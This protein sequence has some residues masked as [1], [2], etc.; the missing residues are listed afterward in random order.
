MPITGP[1]THQ[2][3]CSK[4]HIFGWFS[5]HHKTVLPLVSIS[6]SVIMS[7]GVARGWQLWGPLPKPPW[8]RRRVLHAISYHTRSPHGGKELRR[9]VEGGQGGRVVG[10]GGGIGV[11]S[12]HNSCQSCQGQGEHHCTLYND[13]C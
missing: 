3:K 9:Q 12:L 4:L 8:G 7:R 13:S 1:T 11:I 5:S 2:L 10:L 6:P